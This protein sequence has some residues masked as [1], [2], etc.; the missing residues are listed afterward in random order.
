MTT[1]FISVLDD[2]TSR[3][4]DLAEIVKSNK[5]H[6]LS[7][8]TISSN[9]HKLLI[10]SIDSEFFSNSFKFLIDCF[11]AFRLFCN[12]LISDSVSAG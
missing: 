11:Q 1:A 4:A 12:S 10:I 2:Y 7:G 8:F 5:D 6:F 3:F 9:E